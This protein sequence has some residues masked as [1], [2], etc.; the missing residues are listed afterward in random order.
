MDLETAIC[1]ICGDPVSNIDDV[2]EWDEES[3]FCFPCAKDI[4]D[5]VS[6]DI[7]YEEIEEEI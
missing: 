6:A 3:V 4:S 7:E 2:E 1:Y 5:E